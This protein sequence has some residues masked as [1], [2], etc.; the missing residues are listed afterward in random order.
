M[1]C[2]L[3]FPSHVERGVELRLSIRT[4]SGPDQLI[5]YPKADVVA[6]KAVGDRNV[7][8]ITAPELAMHFK[9]RAAAGHPFSPFHLPAHAHARL[10]HPT[11]ALQLSPCSPQRA[12]HLPLADRHGRR[13]PELPRKCMTVWAVESKLINS[14]RN[15]LPANFFH[16][17][18]RAELR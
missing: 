14:G 1:T 12:S 16:V 4:A 18:L 8:N 13:K 6:V 7:L 17:Y 2:L 3:I 15:M 9:R 10:R 11:S 5:D